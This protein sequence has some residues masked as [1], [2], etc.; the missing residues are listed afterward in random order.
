MSALRLPALAAASWFAL[1]SLAV[2]LPACQEFAN[3]LNA[4]EEEMKSNE[5]NR[6]KFKE[7]QVKRQQRET[8]RM[9]SRAPKEA[10]KEPVKELDPA[11]PAGKLKTEIERRLA[12]HDDVCQKKVLDDINV[13]RKELLLGLPDVLGGQSEKVTIEALRL[14]GLFRYKPAVEAISRTALLA[15]KQVRAEA[16]WA[17]GSIADPKAVDALDRLSR[18]DNPGWVAAAIC[19][20]LGQVG[21]A[22]G[23]DAIERLYASGDR[24][25]RGECVRAAGRTRSAKAR[26]LLQK[27][28]IDHD[29]EVAAQALVALEGL[30]P[31]DGSAPPPKSEEP[32]PLD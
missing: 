9:A 32:D 13:R 14:A 20:A 25:T 24:E 23:L 17:L 15:E 12:C 8:E 1:V 6:K 10:P 4:G 27:G 30:P 16:I 2:V 19:R 7:S 11:T 29:P 5:E 21:D 26:K 31:A 3:T 22:G 18:V 28:T